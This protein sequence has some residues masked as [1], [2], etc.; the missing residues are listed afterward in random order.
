MSIFP[1]LEHQ[2]GSGHAHCGHGV[3]GRV[4]VTGGAGFIGSHI[5]EAYQAA[6]WDVVAL[7]DLSRGKAG[8]VP[9]G[10]P[11]KQLDVR[12]PEAAA[13]VASGGFDLV[14]V[15]AAQIDVRVSVDRPEFDASINVMG[16][17]NVLGGVVKG[18]VKRV[19]FASSGGVVYGVP[20]QVPTPE[21]APKRPLS[22]YGCSK[23]SGEH[24]LRAAAELH[25]FEAVALRYS[26]VFGPRQDPRSGAGVIGIF[27][28]RMLDGKPVV[29]FG[30]GTAGRDYVFVR[31][32]A[33]ASVLASTATLPPATDHDAWAFNIGTGREVTVHQLALA[34]GSRL[35]V[36]PVIDFQPGRPGELQRNALDHAKATRVLGWSP[37]HSLEDG[38]GAVADWMRAGQP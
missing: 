5:C 3:S 12:S 20:E 14:N 35:G 22:P 9:A 29:I 16:L 19:V 24:Y 21:T 30:D 17:I 38:L 34:I 25:G 11:L 6:G 33:Q 7:D 10:V 2:Q 18:G 31:D 4:L 26:N 37:Q 13:F 27:I 32:V 15:Q 36:T 1:A 23:L 28:S 8:N